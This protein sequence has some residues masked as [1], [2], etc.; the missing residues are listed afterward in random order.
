MKHHLSHNLSDVPIFSRISLLA[1]NN[2]N[3]KNSAVLLQDN[4]ND[5]SNAIF[6]PMIFHRT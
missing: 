2:C 4:L 3:L 5:A 1:T 6:L